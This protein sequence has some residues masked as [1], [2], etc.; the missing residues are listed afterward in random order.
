MEGKIRGRSRRRIMKTINT[1]GKSL[2]QQT[3]MQLEWKGF[4]K[5]EGIITHRA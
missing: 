4:K 5:G 1:P 2:H 3:M